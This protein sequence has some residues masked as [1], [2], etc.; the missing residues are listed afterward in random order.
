MANNRIVHSEIP[1]NE[2]E[3]LTQ[4]YSQTSGSGAR[5]TV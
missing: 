3:A 4:F 5:A 1:A 2:P